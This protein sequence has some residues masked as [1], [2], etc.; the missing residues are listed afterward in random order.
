MKTTFAKTLA[1]LVL[2]GSTF[3]WAEGEPQPGM[4]TTTGGVASMDVDEI[5]GK[6]IV[7]STGA[8]LGDIDEVVVNNASQKMA[9]IGLEDSDKEV[10][11]PLSKLTLASDGKNFVTQLT[12]SELQALPDYDPMDMKSVDKV[13]D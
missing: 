2:A 13:G 4:K 7:D 10:A 11:V 1:C 12:K 8:Q 5:E 3:V 6:D 9:V